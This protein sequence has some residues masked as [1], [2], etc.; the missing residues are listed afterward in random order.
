MQLG[1]HCHEGGG[2]DHCADLPV[3]R[4]PFLH[5]SEALFLLPSLGEY[6]AALDDAGR[7]QEAEAVLAFV[8]QGLLFELFHDLV[9]SPRHWC[10]PAAKWQAYD[11]LNG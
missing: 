5:L 3:F 4:E 11:T 1:H 9:L 6:P 10:T 7:E 8:G 2:Q